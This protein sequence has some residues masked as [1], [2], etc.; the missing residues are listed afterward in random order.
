MSLTAL[1]PLL[2]NISIMLSVIAIGLRATFKDTTHLLHR[3]A[4]LARAL[5]SMNVVMPA[6]AVLIALTFN[7]NPAVKIA[8]VALSVSPIP[9][10]LPNK[11]LKAGGSHAY[12]IGLLVAAS[13]LSVVMIPLTMKV[14]GLISGIPMQMGAVDVFKVVLTSILIPLLIGIAIRA[15]SE[16]IA[17]KIVK[18]VSWVGLILLVLAVLPILFTSIRAILTVVGDG[19]LMALAAFAII[20]LILGHLL[21]GPHS[22]NRPVLA[23]AT[24]ARHPA[25]ALAIAH[26][27][28]PNQ[29]VAGALVL[30]Y[31]ALSA[32][33]AAP[34]L[35]WH[36][37]SQVAGPST[38]KRVEA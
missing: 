27:N 4:L 11:M 7:L 3:P 32:I 2:I 18:P 17:E 31:L 5:L 24:S 23:L 19:T 30:V 29:K 16:S 9:P 20:G 28:F 34:Y 37:K 6:V 22:E 21:G 36:K 25:V 26:A 1:I 15:L 35:N 14:F 12:T 33:L 10:I 38:G 8:L 13:L